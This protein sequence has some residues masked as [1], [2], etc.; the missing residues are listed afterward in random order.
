MSLVCSL[1]IPYL[2]C[3]EKHG[4]IPGTL[5]GALLFPDVVPYHNIHIPKAVFIC[6]LV[7]DR[8]KKRY[9]KSLSLN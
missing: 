9:V 3:H 1:A 4:A 8:V 6:G 5:L 7:I 2:I